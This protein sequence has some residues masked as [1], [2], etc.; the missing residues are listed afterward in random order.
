MTELF[1]VSPS[2]LTTFDV[3]TGFGCKRR[4][5]FKYVMKLPDPP[6]EGALLGD[7]LHKR[8]ESGPIG[9]PNADPML[10]PA[11]EYINEVH[12][13][14]WHLEV[15]ID[16]NKLLPGLRLVGRI[17]A[18]NP[19]KRT[20]RDWKTMKTLQ[21]AKPSMMLQK[22][23]QMN[24]YAAAVADEGEDIIIEHV[25]IT[26]Q[27][28]YQ[29]LRTFATS[30]PETRAVL[31]DKALALADGM[32]QYKS[33]SDVNET[34]A[35]RSK[36]RFCAF[37]SNCPTG[38]KTVNLLST[39]LGAKTPSV[40]VP[41]PAA[42][43][44]PTGILPPEVKAE[45][46]QAVPPPR[47]TPPMP[48]LPKKARKLEIQD[49]APEPAPPPPVE[50]VKL[51]NVEPEPD[52]EAWGNAAAEVAEAPKR[53]RG[54]PPGAKNKS[55]GEVVV[56]TPGQPLDA[57][58]LEVTSITVTRGATVQVVQFEPMRI[59]VTATANVRGLTVAE[60]TQELDSQVLAEVVRRM[61]EMQA[62]KVGGK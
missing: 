34:E 30:T 62:A 12:A 1:K 49:V 25:S 31:L 43:V 26:T 2:S 19:E 35:D 46:F 47:S 7:K 33:I 38:E 23:M 8:I 32:L 28:P 42:P 10:A 36:C 15:A 44:V 45:P 3:D 50:P 56:Y 4:W 59:E 21:Y 24:L 37:K 14:G 48:S 18:L 52:R 17:D 11:A 60:A 51:L 27:A 16:D 22:D 61:Q 39:I 55:K 54:R 57:Q 41:T 53:G 9:F 58:G 40:V 6:G 5:W 13:G 29:A 20:I